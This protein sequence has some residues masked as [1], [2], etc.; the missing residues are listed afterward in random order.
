MSQ[1]V[2]QDLATIRD[3]LRGHTDRTEEA[4]ILEIFQRAGTADLNRLLLGLDLDQLFESVDD[5]VFGPDH[6]TTMYRMLGEQRVD[7]LEV[8]ARIAVVDALQY[9]PTAKEEEGVICKVLLAT[10]GSDLTR[11]KNGIDAG[12]EHRDLQRLIFHEIDDQD[13]RDRILSHIASEAAAPDTRLKLLSDIDDTFYASL[14]DKRY[15]RN[16]TYPGVVRFYQEMD[17]GPGDDQRRG[18]IAFVTARPGLP[19]GQVEISTKKMLAERGLEKVTVLTGDLA[20]LRS[21][22]AMAEKKYENFVEYQRIFPEY[23]FV[24]CGDSGQGDAIFGERI[25]KDFPDAVRLIFIHDVVA[26]PPEGRQDWLEKGV[27]F[28]DT[29]VGAAAAT[30]EAGLLP[31]SGLER[32]IAAAS[33]EL[34]AVSFENADQ[35][36]SLRKLFD[37]DVVRGRAL[38]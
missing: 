17:R 20:H 15:P 23:Q 25:K 4:S 7:E 32:V 21:N 33:E 11:L 3:L 2:E 13:L 31:A 18:D 1:T 36:A 22:E 8:P 5:R 10:R 35:E 14:K 37:R 9:G 27:V 12:N 30:C 26:T 16:V 19:T 24:F 38:L 29:Y 6:R 34:D 28:V